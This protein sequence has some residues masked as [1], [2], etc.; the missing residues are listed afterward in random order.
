[1]TLRVVNDCDVAV[2]R[3]IIRAAYMPL[4]EK[5]GD[6]K[7]PA[8]KSLDD[9]LFDLRRERSYAY[10]LLHDE[11]PIGYI[12][13]GE[14]A[15]GEFSISDLAI[16]PDYQGKGYATQF[17][18]EIEKIYHMAKKW[19]LVTVLEEEKDCHLY[20]KMGYTQVTVLEEVSDRMHFVL[21]V[22]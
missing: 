8:N 3:E 17:I 9:L 15:P 20:E 5:Y 12:R 6:A 1:M 2:A 10:F 14:R 11:E 18:R 19:S 21:Y 4:Y 13:V 22:K 7:N 16:H